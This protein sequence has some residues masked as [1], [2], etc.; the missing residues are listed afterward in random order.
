MSPNLQR[1]L[2]RL[3]SHGVTGSDFQGSTV[4]GNRLI[5]LP[6]I[7]KDCGQPEMGKLMLRIQRDRPL[8]MD[9]CLVELP[10]DQQQ[11]GQIEMGLGKL[12]IQLDRPA[13]TSGGFVA[14]PL[15]VQHNSQIG[16]RVGKRRIE[17]DGPAELSGGFLPVLPFGPERPLNC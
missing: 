16:M 15:L 11:V 9:G 1:M 2:Q 17:L 10:L 3:P 8:E 14:P 6:P 12:R 13:V 4:F 5:N 7:D